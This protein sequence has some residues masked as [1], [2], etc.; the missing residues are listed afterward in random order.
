MRQFIT[1]LDNVVNWF[2]K[3]IKIV[4]T[5][6]KIESTANKQAVAFRPYKPKS[7]SIFTAFF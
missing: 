4:M 3:N 1:S 6:K 2:R 7:S 5:K